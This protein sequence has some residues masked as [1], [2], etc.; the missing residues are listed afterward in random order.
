[1]EF[2]PVD[3]GGGGWLWMVIDVAFVI[4]LGLAIWYGYSQWRSRRKTPEDVRRE[5]DAVKDVYSKDTK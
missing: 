4:V 5:R 3:E 1:M 2:G